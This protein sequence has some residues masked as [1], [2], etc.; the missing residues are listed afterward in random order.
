MKLTLQ[1]TS[2]IMGKT[3][4]VFL[5]GLLF[6][7]L[8]KSLPAFAQ[9]PSSANKVGT[10]SSN[11]IVNK[12]GKFIS[13]TPLNFVRTVEPQRPYELETEALSAERTV[14]EVHRSTQYL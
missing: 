14:D 4:E 6:L 13:P 7:V 9:T 5:I 2:K 1:I 11:I 8:F 12:P 3:K 10:P